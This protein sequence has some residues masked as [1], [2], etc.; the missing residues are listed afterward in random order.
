VEFL[1]VGFNRR[2]TQVELSVSQQELS[3]DCPTAFG[4]LR[5]FYLVQDRSACGGLE[6]GNGQLQVKGGIF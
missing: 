5:Q 2:Q 6:K 3:G 4:S 1:G